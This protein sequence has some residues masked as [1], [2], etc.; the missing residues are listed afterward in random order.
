MVGKMLLNHHAS[1]AFR[2]ISISELHHAALS[3]VE[4]ENRAICDSIKGLEL[5]FVYFNLVEQTVG[6]YKLFKISY[7]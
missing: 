1:G 7:F 5:T 2:S 6:L 3:F 4:N